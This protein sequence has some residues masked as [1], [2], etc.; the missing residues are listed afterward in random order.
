MG[1]M[2]RAKLFI[3]I[4]TI[5]LLSSCAKNTSIKE[6][7]ASVEELVADPSGNPVDTRLKDLSVVI[8]SNEEWHVTSNVSWLSTNSNMGGISRTIVKVK[9]QPNLSDQERVGELTF[10]T[11]NASVAVR[12]K[13]L[14]GDTDINTVTYE[15]PVIFHVLYNEADKNNTD[16]LR[17]KYVLNSADAEAML[18]YIN[19]RY[20]NRP[21]QL[22]N[23]IY[24]GIRRKYQQGNI[25]VFHLPL[26]TNIR[27]VLAAENPE[28]K[29][30]SPAGINAIAMDERSLDP[31][32]V[33]DDATGGRFHSMAWPIKK[34]VNVFVFPFTRQDERVDQ[35]VMGISH[36]PMS[37]S[38]APLDG[39][40]TL[41]PESEKY[42]KA[43]GGLDHFS[44]YNHCIT[45]NSD[46]FEWRVWQNTFLKAD[47]GKNTLAHELGHYLGLFH[48]FSEAKGSDGQIILDSCEDTD[49]CTDTKSY[50]RQQYEKDRAE[51]IASGVTNYV[52]ISGLLMRNDCSSGRF[53]ATNIM[54]YDFTH[55][56]EFTPQQI[57]RMRQTL[58]NS[59]TTPGIKIVSLKSI[60]QSDI[61]RP[62]MVEGMPRA[63]ACTIPFK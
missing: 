42:I 40:N 50:N 37:I 55:S 6:L 62:V 41:S 43:N 25:E 34:Y 59:Y 28:G 11:S 27:F 29:R 17:R 30:H 19:E 12:V 26:E 21:L 46:S 61:D 8:S 18:E 36:M 7:T 13:Q 5:L 24:R 45:L 33:M 47:L 9:V 52:Q 54:D 53:E 60:N 4:S 63:I 14:N 15:I 58:Y 22:N 39:L 23:D 57:K 16:T 20:G 38:S 51:I 44:N 56:D 31:K 1:S 10:A 2:R 32:T 49:Y 3:I 35:L 48:T